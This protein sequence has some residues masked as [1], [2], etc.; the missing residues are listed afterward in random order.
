MSVPSIL[1]HQFESWSDFK[2]LLREHLPFDPDEYGVSQRF[3]FRGAE[4][5]DWSLQSSFD[6]NFGWRDSKG[7]QRCSRLLNLFREN[8]ANTSSIELLH[9]NPLVWLALAR[10]HALPTPT[11]DWSES[12]YVAAYFAYNTA[13]CAS[14]KDALEKLAS[15]NKMVAIWALDKLNEKIWPRYPKEE[16]LDPGGKRRGRLADDV[17]RID[18]WLKQ[19]KTSNS[20]VIKKILKDRILLFKTSELHNER[21]SRQRGWMTYQV[22]DQDPLDKHVAKQKSSQ[23]ILWKFELPLKDAATAMSDLHDMRINSMELMPDDD[24]RARHAL[25]RAILE[26]L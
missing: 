18:A 14:P 20:F 19:S 7:L 3:L 10:H 6:R 26:K 15:S 1:V 8:C 5:A 11:L 9:N 24:G 22:E 16:R 12:P 2:I 17:K 23:T 21:L 25:G 13:L 4:D